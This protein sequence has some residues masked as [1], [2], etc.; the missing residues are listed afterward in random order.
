MQ[1]RTGKHQEMKR[2]TGDSG[3]FRMRRNRWVGHGILVR[4]I[5]L[6][7]VLVSEAFADI[8][9]IGPNGINSAVTGLNGEGVA[10]GQV[11]GGRPGK[12]GFDDDKNVNTNVVPTKV[13]RIDDD[14]LKNIE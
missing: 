3:Q 11:E 1:V 14:A 9:T 10:I 2:R 8:D 4:M 12:P 6:G 5:C 7:V 13:F